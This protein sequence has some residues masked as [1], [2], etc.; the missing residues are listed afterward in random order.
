MSLLFACIKSRF[1]HDAYMLLMRN[2]P[3]NRLKEAQTDKRSGS[4]V[5]CKT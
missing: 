3:I 2:I 1:S 5:E 4:V